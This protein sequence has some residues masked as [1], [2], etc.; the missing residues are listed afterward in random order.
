MLANRFCCVITTPFGVA[1][2]PDVNCTN[3]MSLGD[4]VLPGVIAGPCSAS[5]GTTTESAGHTVRSA[6]ICGSSVDDVTTATALHA[7]RTRTVASRYDVRSF[8]IAGG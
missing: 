5:N 3:A 8:V 1:V 6:S 7:C 2:E 4:G